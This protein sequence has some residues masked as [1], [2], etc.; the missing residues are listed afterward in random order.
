M[1]QKLHKSN[2][3]WI[4]VTLCVHFAQKGKIYYHSSIRKCVKNYFHLV[5]S[6]AKSNRV[7]SP[8]SGLRKNINI[9]HKFHLLCNP[10]ELRNLYQICIALLNQKGNF[11][12]TEVLYFLIHNEKIRKK[13][14]NK[15]I[16]LNGDSNLMKA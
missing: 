4:H 6:Q 3:A 5:F 11:H 16:L 14:I 7:G 9:K 8:D 12:F 10:N 13:F 2:C 1:L 15:S